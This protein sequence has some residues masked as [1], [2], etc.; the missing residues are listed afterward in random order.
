MRGD[1]IKSSWAGLVE[2]DEDGC[3][4]IIIDLL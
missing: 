4:Y 2:D 3:E 1:G